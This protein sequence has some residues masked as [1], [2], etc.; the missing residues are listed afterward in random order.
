MPPRPL[1]PRT[2]PTSAAFRASTSSLL[3]GGS[4]VF[5]SRKQPGRAR[6]EERVVLLEVLG[7]D[8][9][10]VVRDRRRP[11][12]GLLAELLDRLGGQRNRRV[13]VA[14]RVAEHQDLPRLGRLGRRG[15]GQRRHHL[16]HVVRAGRLARRRQIAAA[17]ARGTRRRAAAPRPAPP[18]AG[19]GRRSRLRQDGV[20]ALWRAG[21]STS[22]RS[23]PCR[24]RRTTCRT[25]SSSR[26][27]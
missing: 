10:R 12:A 4:V 23:S 1:P 15:R 2:K 13:H 18:A 5:A 26:R 11:G 25:R 20:Q 16:R 17:A 19:C 6:E 22:I 3:A 14:A 27:A 9:R 21:R 24:R 7:V 8:V